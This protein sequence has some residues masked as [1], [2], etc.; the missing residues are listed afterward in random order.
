MS[1]VV[2]SSSYKINKKQKKKDDIIRS[3]FLTR[4]GIN[5]RIL[6]VANRKGSNETRLDY[7]HAKHNTSRRNLLRDV[8]SFSEPLKAGDSMQSESITRRTSEVS[9]SL[10]T[11]S[12]CSSL[13]SND[14]SSKSSRSSRI[15]FREE[16]AVVP[17]PMR[18]EYSNRVRRRLWSNRYEI[19][20]NAY[21]NAVEFAA[22]GWDWRKVKEDDQ[23]YTCAVSGERIHPVHCEP[24]Y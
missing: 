10:D 8:V 19:K 11:L 20:E 18:S 4:L 14:D 17:I 9:S 3:R 13:S 15:Q 22:E 2:S 12:T 1:S 5:S 23:M 6:P 24:C 16:V 7:D 21:R